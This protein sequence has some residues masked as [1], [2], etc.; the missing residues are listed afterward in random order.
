MAARARVTVVQCSHVHLNQS[1][2][3]TTITAYAV[4]IALIIKT[5]G[6]RR[7]GGGV[8]ASVMSYQ[9]IVPVPSIIHIHV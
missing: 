9:E 6:G 2:A 8:H 3:A 7:G 1:N 5:E 4:A